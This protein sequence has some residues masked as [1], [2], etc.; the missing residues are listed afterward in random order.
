MHRH[1]AKSIIELANRVFGDSGKAQDWLTRPRIQLGG[2]SP[3]QILDTE[4]G[5]RRVE[6]LLTQIDD[7]RR[8][9]LD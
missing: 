4:E 7:D 5:V 6:E 8:V 2:R 3:M 1:D 9:G